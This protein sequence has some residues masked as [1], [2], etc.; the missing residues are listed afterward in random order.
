MPL[1]S[2]RKKENAFMGLM[3]GRSGSGKSAA[4]YSFPKPMLIFDLDLRLDGGLVPWIDHLDQIEYKS[5]APYV[6][7]GQTKLFERLNNDF[8]LLL[9]QCQTGQC[10]YKTVVFDSITHETIGL[11]WDAIPLTHADNKGRKLGTMQM[12]GPEDYKFQANGTYQ[13]LAFLKSLAIPNIIC[14][15]HLTNKYGKP[16]GENQY[17]ESII[18]G[19]QLTLTDKMAENCLSYFNHVLKFQRRDLGNAIRHEVSLSGE[20]AR[21]AFHG[22]P[23]GWQ[24]IT[25]KHFYNDV[26]L[27]YVKREQEK[28]AVA[29]K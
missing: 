25:G 14:T 4:S 29:P 10:P 28:E 17:A 2:T 19:E 12:A 8:E 6:G 5:Y 3:I 20:L 27:Q 26:L 1:A 16:P 7:K 18:V 23:Y 24:D 21:T 22:V 13:L 15:A 11:L 9:V